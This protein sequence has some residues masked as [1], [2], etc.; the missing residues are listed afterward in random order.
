MR[1][2]SSILGRVRRL[3][4][5]V[6]LVP[7]LA[8]ATARA[9][10]AIVAATLSATIESGRH[11]W[12]RWPSFPDYREALRRLYAEQGVRPVW[13]ADGA[14]TS[15]GRAAIAQLERA[16]DEGLHASD[17]DAA[18]LAQRADALARDP[19]PA[20]ADVALLDLA[21]SIGVMR[22]VSDLRIGRI[23]PELGGFRNDV[24][25]RR[26]DLP[27]FVSG[28][29]RAD[30]VAARIQAIEPP[31]RRYERLK[32]A[33]VRYRALAADPSLSQPLPVARKLVPGDA[34]AGAPALRHKLVALGDLPPDAPPP[35]DE[36]RYDGAL[37]AAV[38]RFQARHS[39]TADGVVGAATFAAL[40][41]PL[42]KRVEQIQLVLERWRW[43]PEIGPQ[44]IGVNV[45]EFQL[46]AV[47]REQPG[48]SG[49]DLLK[50]RV[51]VG[52]AFR[53]ETPNFV[54]TM[55]EVIF[56]PYWNVPPSIARKEIV[57]KE[58]KS[59]G[60]LARDEF[61]IVDAA[62]VPQ[63][64]SAATLA[65]VAAGALQVRQR[66]GPKNALGLVKF[67]FPNRFN[68]YLHGTP[69]P[70]LF[71]KSRRDFS[72]GCIRVEDPVAL[73]E[74]VLRDEP[75]WTRERILDAMNGEETISVP[76]RTRVPVFVV[77]ATAVADPDGTVRFFEDLYGQDAKL[78]E[79]LAGGYPYRP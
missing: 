35:P 44:L 10:D 66:P 39:L 76:L 69:A 13:I 37:A 62:G 40:N 75:G 42:A 6:L 30:D 63:P 53:T 54:G 21:L 48:V 73:A 71:T 25:E 70:S 15:Q 33:L 45:P 57:P 27:S 72:H 60:Y 41:T 19:S 3:A 47:R 50:M 18:L 51:I 67:L 55:N 61:E 17:Y 20:D 77:Y 7:G 38:E 1:R 58:R 68:V 31:Y 2:R 28:L 23:R 78:S 14:L 26:V 52:R 8:A 12:L 9:D 34:Y 64:T 49:E 65:A 11:P 16:D 29:A 4:L 5:G 56:R 22:N 74:W 36:T 79:L 46:Y 59:P 43:L 24:G 32:E